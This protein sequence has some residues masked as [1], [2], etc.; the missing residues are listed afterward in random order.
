MRWVETEGCRNVGAYA[1]SFQ[2]C[3]IEIVFD[4]S[5]ALVFRR[6]AV[7]L[8]GVEFWEHKRV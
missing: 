1:I 4:G 6:D 5:R 8:D 2:P 3:C 7:S